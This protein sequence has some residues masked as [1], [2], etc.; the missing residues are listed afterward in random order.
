MNYQE[1]EVVLAGYGR[2]IYSI[3]TYAE[4]IYFAGHISIIANKSEINVQISSHSRLIVLSCISSN[5]ESIIYVN[6]IQISR[7][8]ITACMNWCELTENLL[9]T[10]L[11]EANAARAE[12]VIEINLVVG[13][14]SGV[15]SDCVQFN[16]DVLKRGTIAD[17][18]VL[19]FKPVAAQLKCRDCHANFNP[20]DES[21][22]LP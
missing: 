8:K 20:K 6:Q 15:V 10:V 1:K 21:L 16:F 7:S 11:K 12:R 19:H 13:E 22:G 5:Q 4:G 18:A 3:E 14:L 9:A 17:T 2:A